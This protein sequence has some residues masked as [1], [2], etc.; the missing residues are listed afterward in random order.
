MTATYVAAA[1]GETIVVALGTGSGP[2]VYAAPASINL[3]RSLTLTGTVEK[4]VLARTDNPSAPGET[5][6]VVTS[7]D[8]TCQGQGTLNIGDDVVWANLLLAGAPVPVQISN[9][10]TGGVVLTGVAVIEKMEVSSDGIGKK[11]QYNISLQGA[12]IPT[13][14][15]HA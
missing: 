6:A 4:S 1:A 5:V 8:W 11:A 15:S 12:G 3:Q 13:I 7:V 10:N 2:I 9:A 14:T